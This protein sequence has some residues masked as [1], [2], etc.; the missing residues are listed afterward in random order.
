ML[1]PVLKP[2]SLM[3]VVQPLSLTLMVSSR[4]SIAKRLK[5]N[6][7]KVANLSTYYKNSREVTKAL[8]LTKNQLLKPGKN[9]PLVKS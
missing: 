7:I 8:A 3:I 2:K 9:S 5:S 4:M 1:Q 6:M